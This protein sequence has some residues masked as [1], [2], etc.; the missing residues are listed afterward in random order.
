MKAFVEFGCETSN[1][2]SSSHAELIINGT[3]TG[4]VF[5]LL[6]YFVLKALTVKVEKKHAKNAVKGSSHKMPKGKKPFFG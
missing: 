2:K 3:L 6:A 5:I 4:L 1:T